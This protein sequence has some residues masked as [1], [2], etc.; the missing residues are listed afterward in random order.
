MVR[1]DDQVLEQRRG[2]AF[3]GADGV[4]ERGHRDDPAFIARHENGAGGFIGQD[5]LERATLLGVVRGEL[6]LHREEDTEQRH[7]L[8]QLIVPGHAVFHRGRDAN[9][10]KTWSVPGW[11]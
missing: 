5:F 6:G 7:Q 2:A 1:Q 11:G 10:K 9:P 8:R 3:G 4:D